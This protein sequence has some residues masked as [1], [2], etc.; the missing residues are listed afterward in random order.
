[1]ADEAVGVDALLSDRQELDRVQACIR[2]LPAS[3]R[4]PLLLYAVEE[5]SQGEVA[6]ALG[7][8]EKAVEV[9]IYRARKRLA[10]MLSKN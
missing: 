7:L 3:L 1:M 5:L 6:E 9:R 2:A 8:S 4:E 10:E